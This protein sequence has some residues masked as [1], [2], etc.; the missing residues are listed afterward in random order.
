MR[1]IRKIQQQGKAFSEAEN[2]GFVHKIHGVIVQFIPLSNLA[3]QKSK[4]KQPP[5]PISESYAT[6]NPSNQHATQ[7]L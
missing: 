7:H 1:Q 2:R 4:S 6:S 3:Y 5:F